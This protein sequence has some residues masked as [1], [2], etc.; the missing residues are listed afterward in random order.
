[1]KF[2]VLLILIS[3]FSVKC[4]SQPDPAMFYSERIIKIT[5]ELKTLDH[6][7][8]SISYNT[9]LWERVEMQVTL[10]IRKRT[11]YG[12][13]GN[14][15]ISNQ[16]INDLDYLINQDIKIGKGKY[17]TTKLSFLHTRGKYYN[18]T[19]NYSKALVD[20]FQ[21]IEI[22][23]DSLFREA[24]FYNIS[25]TY[26]NMDSIDLS[27]FYVDQILAE[28]INSCLEGSSMVNW[29]IKILEKSN[30]KQELISFY[31]KLILRNKE[32]GWKDNVDCFK[33]RLKYLEG[34]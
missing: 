16:I 15:T 29:K 14:T 21:I 11:S 19:S 9:L 31:K 3:L 2:S 25:V 30:R 24:T 22:D 6:E 13:S 5:E 27:L 7:K 1:M 23:N 12:E 28:R 17:Q 20:Y 33:E 8:D 10:Q 4:F 26:L 34:K 18:A 32:L